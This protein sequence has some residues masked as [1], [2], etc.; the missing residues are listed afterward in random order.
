MKVVDPM[1]PRKIVPV[2]LSLLMPAIGVA[3]AAQPP[4]PGPEAGDGQGEFLR[5]VRS[6]T[7]TPTALQAAIV[8]YKPADADK[9]GLRVDL[10]AAVHVAEKSYYRQLNREFRKYDAVL[11]ELV[12]Q[13]GTEI[14]KG[15]GQRRSTVSMFQSGMKDM[16]ELEFQL[17]QIDYTRKNMVHADM[18]PEQFAKSMK[19]RGESVFTMF[20]RMLGYAIAKQSAA[21]GKSSDAELLAALFDKNRALALKRV[22]AEQIEDMDGSF[23]VLDGPD[24]STIIGERNKVALGVLRKQI[25]AGRK[26][27]A[28]FY[29]AGHMPDFQKRL[30]NEFGLKAENARWLVAW[31]LK[32]KP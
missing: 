5:V 26:K 27:I 19:K 11:Y 17:E 8:R 16:L 18:S 4:A 12:A 9:K 32:S 1:I 24:G 28:I 14:P 3:A 13:E 21:S 23:I 29:G 7:K 6:A 20:L 31:D 15:G 30:R 10:V 25:A 22:M 2:V